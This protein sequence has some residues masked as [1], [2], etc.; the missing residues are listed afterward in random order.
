M[1]KYEACVDICQRILKID[2]ASFVA[3]NNLCVAHNQ[4]GDFLNGIKYGEMAIKINPDSKLAKNNLNWS[5]SIQKK[6]KN[7]Q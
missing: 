4:M 1:G 7:D 3:Y 5:R 2:P 6:N